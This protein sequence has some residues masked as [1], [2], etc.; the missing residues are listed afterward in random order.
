MATSGSKPI[1]KKSRKNASGTRSDPGWEHGIEIDSTTKKVQCKYCLVIRSG[2]IYRLKHHLAGTKF[3]VEACTKVPEKVRNQFLSI[4]QAH[5][6]RF[7]YTSAIPFNCVKNP[8]FISMI[9]AIGQHGPGMKPPSYNDIRVKYLKQEVD[10]TLQLL[11]DYKAEWRKVGCTIMSDGWSDRKRRSICNFLVNSPKGT[12]F[13]SSIDTSDI[14]KTSEK[15]FQMLDEVVEKVGEE[16]VV[17]VVTDN[18]SNYKAAGQMLMEKR[19]HLYWTPCAAHCIDLILEDFEKKI[20]LHK[21]TIAKGRKITTYIYSRTMVHAWLLE[22]TKGRELIRPAVTRFATAYL[23]LGCLSEN[24]GGLMAMFTSSKWKSSRFAGS[25]EGK[26]IQK[27]VLNTGRF[28]SHVTICLK[29]AFPLIKVL[30]MVDSEGPMMGFIYEQMDKAKEKIQLN[31]DNIKKKYEP[32][33]AIID[34]RWTS[35][36]HRPLHAAAYYLNPH[37]HFSPTFRADAEVKIGFYSCLQR[38]IPNEDERTK[39][40]IQMDDFKHARGLFGLDSAKSTRSKRAPAD[41]WDSYGDNCPELKKFAIRVL[42]LTCSSSG[43]ER[44]WS[45]FEM[46]SSK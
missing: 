11:E 14:S 25:K 30:R 32:I 21:S 38:M 31:F 3:N 35:Q 36:L 27:I 22:F 4:L 12:V 5:I 24:K 19:K 9:E 6:A 16:N 29:A 1:S 10:T 26:F 42:S 7:F 8:E 44:N 41:W 28:W 40:D 45:A 18:A 15:V 33:W 39:I 37:Y 34:E 13:L 43:C 17:Q 23:T 20:E 2:G 46:V